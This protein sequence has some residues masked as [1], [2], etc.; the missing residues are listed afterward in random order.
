[1]GS[2]AGRPVIRAGRDPVIGVQRR[3][4]TGWEEAGY[5]LNGLHVTEQAFDAY[6]YGNEAIVRKM[7]GEFETFLNGQAERPDPETEKMP[8]P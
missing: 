8:G 2:R 6:R 7:A 1:M 5:A 3:T 4:A